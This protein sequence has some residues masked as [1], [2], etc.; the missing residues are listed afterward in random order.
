M[1][2]GAHVAA[3]APYVP[4][5]RGARRGG[6]AAARATQLPPQRCQ[7]SVLAPSLLRASAAAAAAARARRTASAQ[8]GARLAP[9]AGG[10]SDD[11]SSE[12]AAS[13]AP[14]RSSPHGLRFAT[15]LS[16]RRTVAGC[17][18]EAVGACLEA[19]GSD[20]PPPDVVR[21]ASCGAPNCLRARLATVA[22]AAHLAPPLRAHARAR[23]AQHARAVA[24]RT[25]C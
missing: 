13:S 25:R 4:R 20:A 17:L 22:C 6:G 2:A 15:A 5:V 12:D 14:P 18:E 10:A 16:R 19:L 1:R 8:R 9:R 21:N 23:L 24:A 7:R 11:S 3:R